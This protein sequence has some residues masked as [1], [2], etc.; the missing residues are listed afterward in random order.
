M[1]DERDEPLADLADEVR[2]RTGDRPP[3]ERPDSSE[4]PQASEREGPLADVASAVD[5]RRRKRREEADGADAFESV[6]VGELDGEKLWEQLADDGDGPAVT[7]P[8]EE[9]QSETT[10]SGDSTAAPTAASVGGDR[11]ADGDRDVRTIPK[12]TC[13]G[14]PHFGDPP[15]VACTHEGTA[16]LAMPDTDHFRV[17]DCPMVADDDEDIGGLGVETDDAPE[18]G[19]SPDAADALDAGE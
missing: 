10:A 14:C 4:D 1:S 6:E 13:H 7:V 12:D 8:P 3:A 19:G 18:T 15:E 5:E 2:E 11:T 16:I 17:A 9:A